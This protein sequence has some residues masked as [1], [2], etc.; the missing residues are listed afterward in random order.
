M[1]ASHRPSA[2]TMAYL[3][4]AGSIS[5]PPAFPHNTPIKSNDR[6]ITVSGSGVG[7][8]QSPGSVVRSSTYANAGT[9][10]SRILVGAGAVA[11]ARSFVLDAQHEHALVGSFGTS[12]WR[13]EADNGGVA[14]LVVALCLSRVGVELRR[15]FKARQGKGKGRGALSGSSST[16]VC[17]N[18]V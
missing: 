15:T 1:S 6:L 14:M 8:S 18:D 12:G 7:S 17:A 2:P 9:S 16:Q 4:G 10:T 5:L 11:A 13:H 3:S